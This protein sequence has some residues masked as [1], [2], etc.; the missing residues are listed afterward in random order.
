M[1]VD[2]NECHVIPVVNPYAKAISFHKRHTLGYLKPCP[3]EVYLAEQNKGEPGDKTKPKAPPPSKNKHITDDLAI[4]S[5]SVV[6]HPIRV[7]IFK[8]ADPA[9]TQRIYDLISEFR[10]VFD[11]KGFADIPMDEWMRIRLRDGQYS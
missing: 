10:D 11:D 8:S 9:E 1:L 6:T 7:R 4:D 2:P 5:E 3:P